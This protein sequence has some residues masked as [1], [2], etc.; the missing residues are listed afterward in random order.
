MAEDDR[1]V[2][3][4]KRASLLQRNNIWRQRTTT[5]HAYQVIRRLHLDS[6]VRD[7]ELLWPTISFGKHLKN[8][9]KLDPV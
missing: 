5:V 2:R 7:G 3:K 4:G 1:V 8:T 6:E 9:S